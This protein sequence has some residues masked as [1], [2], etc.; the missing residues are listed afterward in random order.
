MVTFLNVHL[1]IVAFCP[2]RTI[3]SNDD[4][5]IHIYWYKSLQ[6]TWHYWADFSI[7]LDHG[8]CPNPQF[9]VSGKRP[10]YWF[11]TLKL[12]WLVQLSLD[13]T[14]IWHEWVLLKINCRAGAQLLCQTWLQQ[15]LARIR[16]SYISCSITADL[17]LYFDFL[18]G[19]YS[20][21]HGGLQQ[22]LN[23]VIKRAFY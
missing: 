19:V 17:Y 5:H 22:A 7:F 10:M 2:W 8:S 12:R 1:S 13:G 23:H 16:Q 3:L 18:T 15:I 11:W 9:Y 14:T 6:L 21:P 4:H 20:Q